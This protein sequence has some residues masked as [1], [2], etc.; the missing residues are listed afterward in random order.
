MIERRTF[1]LAVDSIPLARHFV[2]AAFHDAPHELADRAAV[3]TSELA[4]NAVRHARSDFVVQIETTPVSIR[5]E[6][7]DS[8]AGT[9]TIRDLGARAASGR[10]LRI[11][12]TLADEWGVVQNPSGIGKT[13]WF[14]LFLATGDGAEPP[15]SSLA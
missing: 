5:V 15:L 4:T 6:V 3:M 12:D 10:G 13:V 9:P 7:I 14:W 11:V 1:S 8:G 2:E